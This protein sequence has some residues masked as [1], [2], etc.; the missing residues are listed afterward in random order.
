MIL[1]LM[2]EEEIQMSALKTMD[3]MQMSNAQL[4]SLNVGMIFKHFV[5]HYGFQF[6][7]LNQGIDQDCTTLDRDNFSYLLHQPTC[8]INTAPVE[9]SK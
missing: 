8:N 5:Y 7:A 3:G 9:A 4:K 6:D 2:R 1:S